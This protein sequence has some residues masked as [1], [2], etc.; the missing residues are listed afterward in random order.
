MP[1]IQIPGISKL[2]NIAA[3]RP[4]AAISRINFATSDMRPGSKR[5]AVFPPRPKPT[6]PHKHHGG[7]FGRI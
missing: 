2:K 1:L 3:S 7:R 4:Q 6:G 5:A